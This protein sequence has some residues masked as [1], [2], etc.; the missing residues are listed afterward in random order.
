[1]TKTLG[2]KGV[3]SR[4]LRSAGNDDNV[5]N[6]DQLA[7]PMQASSKVVEYPPEHLVHDA[8]GRVMRL[9]TM[10]QWIVDLLARHAMPLEAVAT[11]IGE[12][13]QTARTRLR[14]LALRGVAVLS[15]DGVWKLVPGPAVPSRAPP[16]AGRGRSMAA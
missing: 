7:L 2:G 4:R 16:H 6:P 10:Q 12:P 8:Q 1:M 13:V 5:P 3:A 9:G 11:G 15:E 14:K